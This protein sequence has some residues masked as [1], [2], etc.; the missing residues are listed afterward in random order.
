MDPFHFID[1]NLSPFPTN[2]DLSAGASVT[3]DPGIETWGTLGR[4]D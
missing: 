4:A 2:E 1:E 3:G